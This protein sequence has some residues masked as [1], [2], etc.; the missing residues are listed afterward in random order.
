MTIPTYTDS[1]VEHYRVSYLQKGYRVHQ[2][3]RWGQEQACLDWMEQVS[4]LSDTSAEKIRLMELATEK[5]NNEKKLNRTNLKWHNAFVQRWKKNYQPLE[6][7]EPIH[8]TESRCWNLTYIGLLIAN[9][10]I[11][12]LHIII[13][14]KK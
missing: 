1:R 14:I 5:M 10:L 3:E 4:L 8:F 12:I 9:I 11:H 13:M 2:A 7:E 6:D